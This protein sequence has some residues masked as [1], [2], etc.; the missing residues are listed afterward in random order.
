MIRYLT[1]GF[2]SSVQELA[3]NR[4]V[5]CADR[6]PVWGLHCYEAGVTMVTRYPS[7]HD[8]ITD[9]SIAIYASGETIRGELLLL[10]LL[11]APAP[12]CDSQQ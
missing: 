9:T 5:A 8:I 11:R 1:A 7:V 4:L 3:L 12:T 2:T 10:L 6:H